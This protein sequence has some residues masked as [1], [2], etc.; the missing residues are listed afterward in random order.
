MAKIP[1]VSTKVEPPAQAHSPAQKEKDLLAASTP[2]VNG[3]NGG[4]G[5]T[6]PGTPGV[7]ECCI[8]MESLD[9]APYTGT[10]PSCNHTFCF[11][12]ISS[13]SKQET[14]CPLC[15]AEYKTISKKIGKKA[16]A[17]AITAAGSSS[18]SSG[19]STGAATRG[20][21]RKASAAVNATE[22]TTVKVAKTSQA[23]F[24]RRRSQSITDE[25]ESMFSLLSQIPQSSFHA[26]LFSALLGGLGPPPPGLF[27]EGMLP[28]GVQLLAQ[29]GG[30]GPGGPPPRSGNAP[31]P[32]G[33][34][35]SSSSSSS[36]RSTGVGS[37]HSPILL[38]DEEGGGQ[39]ASGAASSSSSS[40]A[41]TTAAASRAMPA[42][43]PIGSRR[44]SSGAATS[45]SS[46]SSARSSSS[47]SSANPR[48][49]STGGSSGSGSGSGAG[50][51]SLARE[52]LQG[53]LTQLFM[54]SLQRPSGVGPAPP[55]I[56]GMMMPFHTFHPSMLGLDDS[57]DDDDW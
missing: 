5:A 18:S 31:T 40:R 43:A 42:L 16:A 20:Q 54:Q 7:T 12:C 52:Q 2:Q 44:E 3:T 27:P 35:S 51:G 4:N 26:T 1:R 49:S 15:K 47:S 23:D 10:L 28:P 39:T 6:T 45:T 56:P 11:V 36:P 25:L 17:A 8:C 24:Y 55:R 32:A 13:W 29:V 22:A 53:Q 37:R 41:P 9:D 38:V 50:A 34:S 46:S 19:G 30:G 21:K 33:S 57:D 14:T 48:V